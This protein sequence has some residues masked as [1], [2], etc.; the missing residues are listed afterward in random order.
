MASALA[1]ELSRANLQYEVMCEDDFRLP[2]LKR[3]KAVLVESLSVLSPQEKATAEEFRRAGGVVIAADAGDWLK[4]IKSL[5]GIPAVAVQGPTTVR[6][7]VR[8]QPKRTLVHLLNLNVT[9]LSS[10]QDEV[11]ATE[12]VRLTVRVPF[13]SGCSV[14]AITA[15][16]QGTSGNLPADFHTDSQGGTVEFV[17]PRLDVAAI[18]DIE[19][20]PP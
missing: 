18:V 17:V 14:R 8:D 4:Q 19:P 1:A 15:D 5:G 7:V 11:H 12:N 3:A 13:R 10:F 6:A 9:R 2:R 16:A 20:G